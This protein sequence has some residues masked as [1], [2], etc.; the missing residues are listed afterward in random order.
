MGAWHTE[1]EHCFEE[2]D[3]VMVM[4]WCFSDDVTIKIPYGV[5]FYYIDQTCTPSFSSGL[6]KTESDFIVR[7]LETGLG[8]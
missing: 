7:S 2:D 5:M 1:K 6:V 4:M 8:R 3:D